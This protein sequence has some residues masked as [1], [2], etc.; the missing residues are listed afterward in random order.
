MADLSN[1]ES[2]WLRAM[3]RFETWREE[4]DKR[5]YAPA[6]E[7]MLG[8]ITKQLEQL[9][10]EVKQ[11]SRQMNPREWQDLDRMTAETRKKRSKEVRYG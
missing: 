1:I 5:F 2:A 3:N 8:M 11:I 6:A 9:P 10:P 4:F 7:T